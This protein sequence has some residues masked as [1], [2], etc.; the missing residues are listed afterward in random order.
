MSILKTT[1]QA[2]VAAALSIGG[3]ATGIDGYLKSVGASDPVRERMVGIVLVHVAPGAALGA[4]A[5]VVSVAIFPNRRKSDAEIAARFARRQL[6]RTDLP[7]GEAGQWA[8]LAALT[9]IA[10]TAQKIETENH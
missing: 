1:C 5:G 3:V 8:E 9:D 10:N 2:L 6:Q 4:V 7:L